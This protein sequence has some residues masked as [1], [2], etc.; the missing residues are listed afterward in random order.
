MLNI[1]F[2]ACTKVEFMGPDTLYCS[3][4]RQIL[5][6]QHDLDHDPTMPIIELVRYIFIYYIV[7][8]FHSPRL[9]TF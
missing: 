6:S 5:K 1:S 2:L 9:I 3:Q 7:F 8:Q 4:W